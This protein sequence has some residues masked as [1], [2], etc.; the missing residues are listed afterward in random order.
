MLKIKSI[1]TKL[2][3]AFGCLLLV[4]CAGLSI[5]TYVQSSDALLSQLNESL[6]QITKE[7]SK[8]VKERVNS[9]INAL[10]VI[11]ETESIKSD[12]LSIYEK[13]VLLKKEV[14]RS[15]HQFMSLIDENGISI[16]TNGEE[17][18]VSDRDYF[19]KAMLGENYVTDPIIS[20]VDG[21]MI[22][23]YAVP[24]KKGNSIKGVLIAARDGNEL[25][26]SVEDISFGNNS[27]A[28]MINNNGTT[29]AHRNRELVLN[30]DNDLISN[31]PK[32]ISLIEL[33]QKMIDGQNGVGEYEYNGIKK[34]MAFTPVEGTNWSLAI[35]SPKS[36]VMEKVNNLTIIIVIISFIF[37][38]ISIIL[39][40]LI[41]TSISKPI[42]KVS[43]HLEVLSSGDFTQG[44]PMELLNLNDE[45]G[46][47]ARSMNSMQQ[48]LG[49][50]LKGVANESSQVSYVL[51]QINSDMIEL[52]KHIEEIVATTEELS[53]S[54]EET[55]SA[56]EE[57]NA[58]SLEIENAVKSVATKSQD[59]AV[60]ASDINEMAE[61]MKG[62]A[63]SSKKTAI[64]IYEKNKINMENAIEESKTVEQINMLAESI[65][66][67]AS[68]TN[69]L[70]LNAAI[71]AARAGEAGKGFAVV[72]DE[73][74]LLAVNSKNTVGKIQE[75]TKHILVA[76]NDLSSSANEIIGFIDEKVLKDYNTLVESSETYSNNSSE[77][78][79]LVTDFSAASEEILV[80][81]QSMVAALSQVATASTEGAQGATEIAQNT[82][83][84]S[85]MSNEVSIMSEDAKRKSDLLIEA[86]SKFKV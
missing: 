8:L 23:I 81:M 30:M 40:I 47:L 44:V 61:H 34:Y 5:I 38:V 22:I 20:K 80:S 29:I 4:I 77:I 54:T 33:E 66:D 75:V 78:Y 18:N 85:R 41:A 57:M 35:T 53:A 86:V 55:A 10:E 2:C 67:I 21:S 45:V 73:I 64:S 9:Q 56:T 7:S 83:S 1:K 62:S 79:N 70:A 52:N 69:L 63:I 65:L 15:G 13:I 37:L 43:G 36:N 17:N 42:K 68:Q 32:L 84:V 16:T 26:H 71:E 60:T 24:I 19:K 31:N 74:R 51:S 14:E 82:S 39:T 11:A 76:V 48:A 46:V 50:I 25:S 58:T 72:A 28:F 3:L 6:V 27:E 12:T 49:N 59:G